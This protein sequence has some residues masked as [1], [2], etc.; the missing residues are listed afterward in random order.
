MKT[1]GGD[2]VQL[3]AFLTL[4]LDGVSAQLYALTALSPKKGPP[5][6]NEWEAGGGVPE[7]VAKKKIP[8]P[9]SKI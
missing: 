7:P 2:E 3:H 8:T 4:V 9:R 6:L 1:Y 5:V